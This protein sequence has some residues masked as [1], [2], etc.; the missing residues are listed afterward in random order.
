[1]MRLSF[2]LYFCTMYLFQIVGYFSLFD[3]LGF[4]QYI[5][6]PIPLILL[7]LLFEGSKLT[8]KEVGK[9]TGVLI[10]ASALIIGLIID[11]IPFV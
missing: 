2:P 10:I 8:E 1:M 3:S 7:F 6:A 5:I 9:G 4:W 11:T